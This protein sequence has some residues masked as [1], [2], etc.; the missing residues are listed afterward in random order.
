VTNDLLH[1]L[2]SQWSVTLNGLLLKRP[3]HLQGILLDITDTQAQCYAQSPHE[4]FLVPYW[5]GFLG[6]A[7]AFGCITAD[8]WRLIQ[9]TTVILGRGKASDKIHESQEQLLRP[10][11]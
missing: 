3:V 8:T 2:F 9:S 1:F 4:H 11:F 7:P 10:E 6:H 5:Q